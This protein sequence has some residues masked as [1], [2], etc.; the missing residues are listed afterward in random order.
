MPF[1]KP[2][3]VPS[4]TKTFMTPRVA[5]VLGLKMNDPLNDPWPSKAGMIPADQWTDP[6]N[7]GEP[8]ITLW[9]GQTSQKAVDWSDT[10]SY[11]P[12]TL[13]GSSSMIDTRAGCV[14]TAI[15]ST[16]SRQMRIESCGRM[17]GKL[18]TEKTEGRV[19]SCGV[20]R[21]S[22]WD[23]VDI[24]CTTKDWNAVRHCTEDQVQFLDEQDQETMVEAT[25]ELEKLGGLD[26]KD[27]DCAAVRKKWPAIKRQ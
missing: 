16:T 6:D 23:T 27:I 5:V 22:E 14:S 25:F 15:R 8:G 24:T 9:P 26:A 13:Q 11:L 10:Y 19:H 20:M 4:M 7:D 1:T 3:A 17:T 2:D 12:V 18:F 21:M